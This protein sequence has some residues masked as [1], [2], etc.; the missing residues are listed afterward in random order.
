[1]DN[2]IYNPCTRSGLALGQNYNP[3]SG[4]SSCEDGVGNYEKA[5]MWSSYQIEK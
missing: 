4:A 2:Y 1:M 5:Y 3:K